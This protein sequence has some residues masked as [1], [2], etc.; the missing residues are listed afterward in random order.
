MNGVIGTTALLAETKLDQEQ[1]KYVDI[2][3]ASGENLLSVINDILDFSKIESGKMEIE[4]EP[5][6][7]RSSI[8]EVFDLFAGKAASQQLDLVYEI[9]PGVTQQIYG[10]RI[11]LKQILMNLIGNSIKFTKR[12]EIFVGAK[13]LKQSGKDIEIRFEVR[14][15]GIG[16]P[17]EKINTL[18]Q[19]FTQVDSS[20]TRKYGGTGLGLAICKRLVELMNGSIWIESEPGKGSSFFFTIKTQTSTKPIR[21]FVYANTIDLNG[22]KILVIDD[23]PTNRQILKNPIRALEICSGIGPVR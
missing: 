9:E 11:R 10:D 8:E 15:T 23:N 18:F 19:A 17:Q 1:E 4:H 20:T 22:K 14:D 13:I 5:Y 7:L 3:K 21:S 16:I 12:G 2:I 6:D